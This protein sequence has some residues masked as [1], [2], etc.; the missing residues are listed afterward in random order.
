MKNVN[1]PRGS[2]GTYDP[3]ECIFSSAAGSGNATAYEQDE[4]ARS[5]QGHPQVQERDE[6]PWVG[7][8]S[9]I[10][11]HDIRNTRRHLEDTLHATT[12]R[13]KQAVQIST[14]VRS[15][16]GSGKK[17]SP[18]SADVGSEGE[19]KTVEPLPRHGIIAGLGCG[20]GMLA[21]M[22]FLHRRARAEEVRRAEAIQKTTSQQEKT[23][24]RP[25]TTTNHNP[26]PKSIQ[27][28]HREYMLESSPG[29]ISSLKGKSMLWKAAALTVG[30]AA[31]A[32]GVYFGLRLKRD[33]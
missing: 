19:E 22:L 25:Q 9:D 13:L 3:E 7:K 5:T 21:R 32:V 24:S 33:R 8:E 10:L 31:I 4:Q 1:I 2:G 29:P 20:A 28:R 12:D 30:S 15:M 26:M 18:R 16:F 17:R 27:G 23:M 6:L 14:M 11:V